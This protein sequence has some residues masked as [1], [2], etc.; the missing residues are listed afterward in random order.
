MIIISLIALVILGFLVRTHLQRR[1]IPQYVPQQL[2]AMK[3]ERGNTLV[4]L[5]V[6]TAREHAQGSIPGSVHIPLQ[7]LRSRA[8]DLKRYAGREIICYCQTG[9]RSIHAASILKKLSFRVGNLKGGIA[10]WNFS[11]RHEHRKKGKN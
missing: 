3:S 11:H 5:D 2:D 10:E 8:M 6:R 9:S 4:L 1:G 7:E